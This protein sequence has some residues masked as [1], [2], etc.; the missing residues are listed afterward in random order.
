MQKYETFIDHELI[1]ICSL[2]KISELW[3]LLISSFLVWWAHFEESG[4]ILISIKSS[5]GLA[6]SFAKY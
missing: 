5:L 3:I 4:G 2:M 6:N 1:F